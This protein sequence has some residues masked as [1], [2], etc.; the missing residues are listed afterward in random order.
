MRRRK[1]DFR[2]LGR[3]Y[4]HHRQALTRRPCS[5][6]LAWSVLLHWRRCAEAVWRRKSH[7]HGAFL[8]GMVGR[9]RVHIL[10]LALP[11]LA[12][13]VRDGY[14]AVVEE[15]VHRSNVP[16]IVMVGP[17]LH[18]NTV[19]QHRAIRPGYL[20]R[21]H[22][23]HAIHRARFRFVA[24]FMVGA[25]RKGARCE[26]VIH[27]SQDTNTQKVTPSTRNSQN[28]KRSRFIHSTCKAIFPHGGTVRP[29]TF[30]PLDEGAFVRC[31][32]VCIGTGCFLRAVLVPALHELG[33]DVIL[34][35]TR[36]QSFGQYMQKRLDEG[37]GTKYELDTVLHDG[38]TL[39][40]LYPITACGSLGVAE[41][42][43]AFMALPAKLKKLRF[44]GLGVT[45]AGITHNGSSMLALAEF[46]HA[47]YHA[48]RAEDGPQLLILNTDNLP[49]NGDAVRAH[50]LSCDFTVHTGAAGRG[51]LW[52]MA[53]APRLLLP[54]YHGR[55]HHLPARGVPR[56]ASGGAAP[57]QGD[58]HQRPKTSDCLLMA[59]DDRRL[60]PS[61]VLGD[62]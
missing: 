30:V 57:L 34:A 12:R 5:A 58:C 17:A 25:L 49:F 14:V 22:L 50:V 11:V 26:R 18:A 36:G 1:R 53:R 55:P 32:A 27:S 62:L 44:I 21:R 31:S 19:A 42:R 54:Q 46:L 59:T 48:G 52:R 29:P 41:G 2:C 28:W 35:Q 61:S 45:E 39:T 13:V 43:A 33:C 37:A 47:C 6:F 38:S 15:F 8:A 3:I 51:G 23:R 4:C 9:K 60:R 40:T 24:S 7:L 56:G 10:A 16:H 20:R